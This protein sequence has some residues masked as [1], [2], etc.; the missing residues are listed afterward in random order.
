VILFFAV[1]PH[2]ALD[3]GEKAV[4]ATIAPVEAVTR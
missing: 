2:F 4:R 1:Y 3:R